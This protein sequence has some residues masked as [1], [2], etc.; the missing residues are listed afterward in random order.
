MVSSA[1]AVTQLQPVETS[2]HCREDHSFHLGY[3]HSTLSVSTLAKQPLESV[4]PMGVSLAVKLF[5]LFE[6][7]FSFSSGRKI[8]C[9]WLWLSLVM[10]STSKQC[11]GT[12]KMSHL[13]CVARLWSYILGSLEEEH[14]RLILYVHGIWNVTMFSCNM[15]CGSLKY[16]SMLLFFL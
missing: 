6:N 12:D 4:L 11:V 10:F 9:F 1:L 2:G 13:C 8:W 16:F 5:V 3:W 15:K 14:N 7:I